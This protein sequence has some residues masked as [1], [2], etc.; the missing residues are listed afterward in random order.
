MREAT[1]QNKGGGG[2]GCI[3]HVIQVGT[4]YFMQSDHRVIQVVR[5]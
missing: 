2:G 5:D 1:K 3:L 4:Y